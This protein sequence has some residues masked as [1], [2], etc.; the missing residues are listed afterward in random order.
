[1]S[2]ETYKDLQSLEVKHSWADKTH[3]FVAK[4]KNRVK[5]LK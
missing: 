3:D 2:T 5:F 1:M 4:Y